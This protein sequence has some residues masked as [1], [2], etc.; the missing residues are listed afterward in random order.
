MLSQSNR[1]VLAAMMPII[2]QTDEGDKRAK[3]K[4][5]EE[6]REAK[7]CVGA[8]LN[9]FWFDCCLLD[10]SDDELFEVLL[11]R[12]SKTGDAST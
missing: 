9:E 12:E 1:C 4:V 6:E 5:D 8:V 2:A 11:E 10:V 7:P 3:G